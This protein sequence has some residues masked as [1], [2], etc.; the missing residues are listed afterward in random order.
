MSDDITTIPKLTNL[1]NL[2]PN[3]GDSVYSRHLASTEVSPKRLPIGHKIWFQR[4]FPYARI[5]TYGYDTH[6]KHWVESPVSRNTVY[7]IAWDLLV[8]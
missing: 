2:L 3:F 6:I 1:S 5:L 7:D 4:P 8:A